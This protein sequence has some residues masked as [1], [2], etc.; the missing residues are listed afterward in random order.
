MNK[1]VR[2]SSAIAFSVT[3]VVRSFLSATVCDALQRQP[4]TVRLYAKG[5]SLLHPCAPLYLS[6]SLFQEINIHLQ[7]YKRQSKDARR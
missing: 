7:T 6:I 1:C 5:D 4:Q 3:D 2:L